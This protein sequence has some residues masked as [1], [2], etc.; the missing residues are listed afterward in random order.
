MTTRIA[1][2]PWLDRF[3]QPSLEALL[4]NLPEEV[5][6]QVEALRG[7]MRALPGVREQVEWLGLPWRWA[8]AYTGVGHPVSRAVAYL[9]PDPESVRISIPLEQEVLALIAGPKASR[10]LR[11]SI[12]QASRVGQ[13]VWPEWTMGSVVLAEELAAVAEAKLASSQIDQVKGEE[14]SAAATVVRVAAQRSAKSERMGSTH[15]GSK[16]LKLKK[17]S[18]QVQQGD[19]G[20]E[21]PAAASTAA[22]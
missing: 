8:I 20:A 16:A 10:T 1:N 3:T 12:V 7:R 18:P 6:P 14:T 11:D 22:L 19:A 15:A 9:I 2:S 13:I 17:S 5:R 4:G 21:E